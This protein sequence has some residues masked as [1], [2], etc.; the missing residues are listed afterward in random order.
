MPSPD[1]PSA[2]ALVTG[3]RRIGAAVAVALGGRGFDVALAYHASA[4]AAEH[5]AE[6]IRQLGRR[7]VTLDADLTSADACRTLIA[8]TVDSLGRLDAAVLLASR[9]VKTSFEALDVDDWN[10]GLAIDLSASF[11]CA[12]AATPLAR[13]GGEDEVVRL[14]DSLVD[15]T[16]MTGETIRLDGGRHLR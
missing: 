1:A 7:A 10:A 13:W 4:G 15:S 2:V 5:A 6:R 3:T 8:R 14:V 12:Q 9:F 16:F 11:F